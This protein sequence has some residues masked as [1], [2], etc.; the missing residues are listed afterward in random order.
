MNIPWQ[1]SIRETK[2]QFILSD[3]AFHQMNICCIWNARQTFLNITILWLWMTDCHSCNTQAIKKCVCV[4]VCVCFY[5]STKFSKTLWLLP[6]V[7]NLRML[8]K[9]LWPKTAFNIWDFDRKQWNLGQLYLLTIVAL[10][11]TK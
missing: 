6:K 1:C 2:C 11:S 10:D 4:C 5:G 7:Q 3:R 8:L 9:V